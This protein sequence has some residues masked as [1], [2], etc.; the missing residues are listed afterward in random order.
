M[1]GGVANGIGEAFG[2]IVNA[3]S[4]VAERYFPNVDTSKQTILFNLPSGLDVEE[5]KELME[6]QHDLNTVTNGERIRELASRIGITL[7]TLY[8]ILFLE[9]S[10]I[11]PPILTPILTLL[12]M[13]M[14]LVVAVFSSIT[15]VNTQLRSTTSQYASVA[16]GEDTP[17]NK[18]I[19]EVSKS[20]N[21][22]VAKI[23]VAKRTGEFDRKVDECMRGN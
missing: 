3:G 22:N 13:F 21:F 12:E 23:L 5:Y 17:L 6:F 9:R 8:G 15:D 2:S 16:S 7:G 10:K 14:D 11:I 4:K 1:V 18:C 19:I 20:Y